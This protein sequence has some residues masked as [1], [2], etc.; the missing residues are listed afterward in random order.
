MLRPIPEAPPTGNVELAECQ[1]Q[2]LINLER[3]KPV[4]VMT[5]TLFE[6]PML[7]LRLR[8]CVALDT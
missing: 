8:F 5:T 4:P 7:G 6:K 3:A 1:S 2:R